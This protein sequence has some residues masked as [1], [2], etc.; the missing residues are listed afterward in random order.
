MTLEDRLTTLDELWSAWA[1][2]GAGLTGADWPR[3]TRLD[4]WD[5]RAL[6]AHAAGWPFGFSMLVGR[7]TDAEPT[8][9]RAAELLREFNEPGGIANTGRDQV[10]GAARDDAARY[11]TEQLVGQFAVTGPEAVAVARGLGPVT[12][13]YFGRAVLPLAEAVSIGVLEATVHL[14]DVQR[15]LGRTPAVPEAG[16]AHTAEVLAQIAPPVD[17]IEAA[18]GRASADLFPVLS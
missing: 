13:D 7:V 18:T 8:H 10:A 9:R 3:P 6:W 16:L 15:A 14:L 12:V 5:L 11:T 1:A 17:F 2:V 4:G